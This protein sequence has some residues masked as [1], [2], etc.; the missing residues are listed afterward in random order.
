MRIPT[1]TASAAAAMAFAPFGFT[2]PSHAV[3]LLCHDTSVNHM[4]VD[5]AFAS[6]C[7]STDDF[8]TGHGA[9]S[10]VLAIGSADF[11]QN[12]STGT[13]C[14]DPSL[15]DDWSNIARDFQFGSCNRP[16]EG[17]M[18]LLTPSTSFG[19]WR[20]V[21]VFD[22]G[23]GLSDVRIYGTLD[24]HLPEPGTLA[25]LGLGLLATTL[26]RRRKRI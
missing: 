10:G 13:F 19:T 15:W 7:P 8:L 17:F 4:Y 23:G 25:L 16:D 18:L 3:P 26:V 20:F 14:F 9:S 21:N 1:I 22:R 11:T 24:T 12:G 2:T 6:S 5:T